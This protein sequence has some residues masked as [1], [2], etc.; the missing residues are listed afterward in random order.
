MQDARHCPVARDAAEPSR[1]WA[2][3]CRAL[4]VRA[5][6]QPRSNGPTPPS[7]KSPARSGGRRRSAYSWAASPV[8]RH[9]MDVARQS[10]ASNA[11]GRGAQ[12]VRH[13]QASSSPSRP[14][15][16]PSAQGTRRIGCGSSRQGHGPCRTPRGAR[17]SGG[18]YRAIP[19][20]YVG[21][22]AGSAPRTSN[23]IPRRLVGSQSRGRVAETSGQARICSA[24]TRRLQG[25]RSVYGIPRPPSTVTAVRAPPCSRA[26]GLGLRS[27]P[28]RA[29]PRPWC[30]QRRTEGKSGLV[31][32]G[33]LGVSGKVFSTSSPLV[34]CA[35]ASA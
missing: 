30:L 32:L 12:L 17:A 11:R 9:L 8:R 29:L 26:P 33:A 15:P 5:R 16:E 2:I 4:A 6:A 3:A 20:L 7:V 1:I 31:V 35:I 13:G 10:A 14:A 18:R 24:G 27:V 22:P 34:R 25:S 21:P 19:S 23:V 28:A